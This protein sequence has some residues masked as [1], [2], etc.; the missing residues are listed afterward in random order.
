LEE[1]KMDWIYNLVGKFIAGKL[2][3][4]EGKPMETKP[5]YK[6][7]TVWSDIITILVGVYTAAQ[8]GLA[9]DLGHTLPVIPSWIFAILGGI[10]IYGRASADTSL[11]K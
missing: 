1:K 2:K 10:G 8:S 6:S 7:K 11:S 5:W 4:E 3:L 9:A